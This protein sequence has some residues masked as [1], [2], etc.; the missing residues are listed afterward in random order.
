MYPTDTPGK[1]KEDDALFNFEWPPNEFAKLEAQELLARQG[2]RI[3]DSRNKRGWSIEDLAGRTGLHTNTVG[4]IERGQSECS[5]EQLLLIARSLDV[6]PIDLCHFA[7]AMRSSSLEDDQ[8]ALIDML[9]TR[10][11]GGGQFN[12]YN[13]VIGRFA[14]KR[15]WLESRGLKPETSKLMRYSGKAMSDKINHGDVLLVNMAVKTMGHE[16]I[17]VIEL[18]GVDDVKL[19]Q[20][21]YTNGGIFLISYNSAFKT[22]ALNP[23]QAERLHI[24]AEVVWHAEEL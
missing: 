13:E 24:N 10:T 1:S 20:R 5:I 14:F 23:E 19:L 22:V 4:R 2:A 18:D 17:Y 15:R 3:R 21:D 6:R 16:G 7:D 11:S 12:D 8:F 9:D